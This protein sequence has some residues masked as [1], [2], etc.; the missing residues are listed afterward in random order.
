VHLRVTENIVI[1]RSTRARDT[2]DSRLELDDIDAL[3]RWHSAKPTGG[4]AC[5][6][7]NHKRAL[8]MWMQNRADQPAHHLRAGVAARAAIRF[9]VDDERVIGAVDQGHAA[10]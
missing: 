9:A 7:P 5:A 1:D 4:T 6:K 10:F 2:D 3:H 8:G